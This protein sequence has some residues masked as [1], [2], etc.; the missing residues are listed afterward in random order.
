[1]SK[2]E[3]TPK[4]YRTVRFPENVVKEVQTL[5]KKY[6]IYRNHHEFLI[7]AAIKM[8]IKFIDTIHKRKILMTEEKDKNSK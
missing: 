8:L 5:I 2:P 4:K 3:P 6:P 7:D 1:M